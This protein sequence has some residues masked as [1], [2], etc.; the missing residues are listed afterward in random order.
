M[1]T[2]TTSRNLTLV[3]KQVDQPVDFLALWEQSPHYQKSYWAIPDEGLEFIAL[4]SALH[5]G[6]QKR[7]NRF[8]SV[9][10]GI[11]NLQFDVVGEPGPDLS[12]GI[13][14]GGFSFSDR[15]I[16]RHPDWKVFGGGELVLP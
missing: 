15:E 16:E 6:T 4:G 11:R 7:R 12:A 14:V 3:R 2:L 13:L 10:E 8:D 5:F 1:K 9:R